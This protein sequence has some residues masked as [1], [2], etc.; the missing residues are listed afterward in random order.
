[1]VRAMRTFFLFAA[2]G[3]LYLLASRLELS[4]SSLAWASPAANSGDEPHYLL[5]ASSLVFDRDLR[6]EQDYER[7]R[8]GG[9]EAGL[10]FRKDELDHHTIVLDTATGEHAL[11]QDLYDWTAHVACDPPCVR[12]RKLRPGLDP[13]PSIV[14][15][16]AHA[17]GFPAIVALVAFALS[18]SLE[19]METIG[20]GVVVAM[21]LGALAGLWFTARRAGYS[22][23]QSAAAVGLLGVGSPLLAYGRSFFSEPAAACALAL[24]SWALAARRPG[25][26]GALLGVAAAIK[27]PLGLIGLPW[28][29]LAIRD[30]RR[31]DAA[32]V[33]ATVF[34]CGLALAAFNL[35]L[36][37]TPFISGTQ[38]FV[39][40]HGLESVGVLLF[41]NRHGLFNFVP[42]TLFALFGLR[43]A[44]REPLVRDLLFGMAPVV[45]LTFAG[46]FGGG[47]ACY[48]PRYFVPFLPWLALVAVAA[49]RQAT[50]WQAGVLGALAGI[51]VVISAAGALRYRAMFDQPVAQL[52]H[53]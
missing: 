48:G 5:V 6:L 31:A 37:R 20:S 42:W 53:P 24:A 32:W 28:I 17:V 21:C 7:V 51:S 16:P 2:L 34:G 40:A 26:C 9:A 47:G 43:A 4:G 8:A 27:P 35:H 45:L 41:G 10:R 18:A 11:W 44:F 46:D 30:G 23:G 3:A 39:V 29:W 38:G 15:V 14:E 19:R 52:F 50:R 33:A 13:G 22:W 36:A 12:F 49:A 1:M 25:V